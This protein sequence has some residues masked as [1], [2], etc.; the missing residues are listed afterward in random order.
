MISYLINALAR[1]LGYCPA[2]P[3]GSCCANAKGTHCQFC[4]AAM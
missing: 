4:G 2:S 3:D 1:V